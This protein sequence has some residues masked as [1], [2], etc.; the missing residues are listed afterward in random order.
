ME[1]IRWHWDKHDAYGCTQEWRFALADYLHRWY[2]HKVTGFHPG[3]QPD[4]SYA[5][6]FLSD[7]DVT[8][9]EAVYCYAILTRY[10]DILRKE[11]RDY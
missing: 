3:V 8:E 4:N 6:G 11:Q 2:G 9:S 7:Y 1:R 10:R 5:Y